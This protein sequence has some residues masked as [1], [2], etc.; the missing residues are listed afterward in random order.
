MSAA[1]SSGSVPARTTQAWE[2]GSCA[3]QACALGGFLRTLEVEADDAA[4]HADAFA[5]MRAGGLQAVLVHGVYAQPLLERIVGRLERHDPPFLKTSFPGK[6][7]SWF[8]GRNLNLSHPDLP[9]YFAEAAHF[10]AQLEALLPGGD[11]IQARVG[12]IL[13][14]L[15]GGRPFVPAPGAA[16][17][18]RYMFT[19]L[20]AHEEGGY[21]PPHF[22]NEQRLRRSYR[23]LQGIVD[24]HMTSFVLAFTLPEAGGALE[25]FDLVT[26]PEAARMI[27]DDS[28]VDKPDVATLASVS[29]RVPAGS[30]IV[31]D[32]GRYLHRL[33]PV[34]GPRRRWTACSF[35]ASSRRGEATYC[36]G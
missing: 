5:R 7:R 6:F 9:G 26:A 21:I 23:H 29:F 20:R 15:D 14:A 13:A 28:V 17:G 25:V 27:S 32:S 1:Q 3:G 22:D 34:E 16:P 10:N 33:T 11:G 4:G 2:R 35:M 31:L 30:M 12:A 18:E 19:T 8:Y 24:L 36:W